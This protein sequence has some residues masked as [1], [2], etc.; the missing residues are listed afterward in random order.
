VIAV[1]TL[2]NGWQNATTAPDEN[3]LANAEGVLDFTVEYW[4]GDSWVMIPNGSVAGND[5]ALRR[6]TFAAVITTKIRV[7]ITNSRNNW[8]RLVEVEAWGCPAT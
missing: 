7:V 4:D 6:F 2:Q 5:R 8:S 3:T 1:V